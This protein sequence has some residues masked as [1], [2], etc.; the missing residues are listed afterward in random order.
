[1]LYLQVTDHLCHIVMAGGLLLGDEDTL[2]H[3]TQEGVTAVGQVGGVADNH[4]KTFNL[5][6]WSRG[7]TILLS[8]SLSLSL[9]LIHTHTHALFSDIHMHL[10]LPIIYNIITPL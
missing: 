3:G 1:M 2:T 8:L 9:S 5:E 6:E 4:L 10:S 7:F